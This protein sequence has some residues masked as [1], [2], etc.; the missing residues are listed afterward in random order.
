MTN[1]AYRLNVRQAQIAIDAALASAERLSSHGIVTC[2]G[3]EILVEMLQ[4]AQ[5]AIAQLAENTL[6]MPG[7][8]KVIFSCRSQAEAHIERNPAPEG[9]IYRISEDAAGRCIVSI[10]RLTEHL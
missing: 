5:S 1:P 4:D 8:P 7:E 6:Q 3:Y 10:Y 9:T 2:L